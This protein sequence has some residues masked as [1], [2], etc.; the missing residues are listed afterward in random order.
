MSD[1]H[2]VVV[3]AGI[4]GSC[5]GYSLLRD[6]AAV[7]IVDAGRA[8]QAT[9][10]GAGIIQPWSSA[11]T[12]A[13][14]ELQSRSATHYPAL[15]AELADFGVGDVGYRR[16]G[17]LVV[18]SQP[19]LVDKVEAQVRDRARSSPAAGDIERLDGRGARELFPPLAPDL[20]GL[21]IGG[22]ARV[23]G[24]LLTAGLHAAIR[25]LGGS[26]VDGAVSLT[27]TVSGIELR[28]GQERV[29]ADAVV[30]AAGAWSDAL[31]APLGISTGIAPQRGQITHLRLDGV[32]TAGWPS[33]S[34]I[35]H[36]YM[37]AFDDSR[38]VVGATRETGSGFDPRV[39]AEG[40]RQV[41]ADALSI[42]PGL[43]AATLIET[44]VGLRPLRADLIPFVGRV[45]GLNSLYVTSG[46]GPVGL[47]IAPFIGEQV[48]QLILTGRS[49]FDLGAFTP[50]RSDR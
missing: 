16:C 22:G 5:V 27:P 1:L 18:N 30:I 28:V 4:A 37:V 17:A 10:A 15:I 21:R 3:G 2:V 6:G 45:E 7:T 13:L 35:S 26:L 38:V 49:T 47:T 12:G 46:Y 19:H 48:S 23:D 34:P 32:D 25:K 40:Q 33:V 29:D 50:A 24:R 39:T 14:Y 8:G 31:L 36:H 41:L 11:T 44:R 42:A 43:S 9:A 20:V